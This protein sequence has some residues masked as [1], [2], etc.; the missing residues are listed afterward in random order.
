MK[1]AKLCVISFAAG[2]LVTAA[3]G[4]FWI[5]PVVDAQMIV[6]PP[7]PFVPALGSY[8]PK[9]QPLL[10]NLIGDSVIDAGFSQSSISVD[11]LEVDGLGMHGTG[12]VFKYGG[13][14]YSLN[15]VFVSGPVQLELIGA[16][17]NTVRFLEQFGVLPV[18][19]PNKPIF[20]SPPAVQPAAEPNSPI[21]QKL[22]IPQKKPLRGDIASQYGQ[23]P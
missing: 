3:I 6:G 14:A 13:G 7:P 18:H 10:H 15:R 19:D 23:Y 16:A 5:A 17:A 12:A 4:H 2:A 11:G 1:N 22:T 9:V 20:V 8:V 21:K